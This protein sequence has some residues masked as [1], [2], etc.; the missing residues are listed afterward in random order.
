MTID[1][2]HLDQ[3]SDTDLGSLLTAALAE[4]SRRATLATAVQSVTQTAQEFVDIGGD[5]ASLVTAVQA[6][7]PQADQQPA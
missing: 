7:T 4:Q 2:D 6:V 5:K 1:T 3:L